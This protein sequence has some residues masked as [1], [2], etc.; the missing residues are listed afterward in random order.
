LI[1]CGCYLFLNKLTLILQN[2]IYTT[3]LAELLPFSMGLFFFKKIK[4]HGVKVFFF[5][6]LFLAILLSL[7]L[8]FK[9]IQNNKV[10]QLL[11]NRF[12]LIGE[13]TLLCF[14][15]YN[16]L[17]LRNRKVILIIS[18]V[19]FTL[20]SFYDYTTTTNPV[21]FSYRP[22]IVECLF[23]ALL[24]V[25]FFYEKLKYSIEVPILHT[26]EF[27]VS[28]AFLLYFSGNF[29]LFLFS[30]TMLR[31]TEFRT[32]YVIIYGTVTI[33][34]DI[35]L[36]VA[37]LVHVFISNSFKNDEEKMLKTNDLD[38]DPYYSAPNINHKQQ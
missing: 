9:L 13:F 37:I 22:L 30:T 32:Q 31:N 21:D 27:W 23:F 3:Y 33:I 5:Y 2:L 19:L 20:Y 38:I 8:Y 28:V 36:T 7:S 14:Y 1:L 35:L 24:I 29:F 18:C 4:S 11:V 26:P 16:Y 34:K 17:S 15:Y 12:A 6:T 25:F 10:A